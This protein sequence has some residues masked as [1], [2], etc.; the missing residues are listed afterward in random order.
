MV[1]RRNP[2]NNLSFLKMTDELGISGP[3]CPLD[4]LLEVAFLD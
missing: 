4:G 3:P 1:D 2:V